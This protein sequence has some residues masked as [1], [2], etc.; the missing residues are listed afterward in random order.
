MPS[1]WWAVM[2]P[3]SVFIVKNSWGTGW[4]D[5]GFFRIAY[6]ELN[7]AVN[8]GCN[9]IAYDGAY[10]PDDTV[11]CSFS[12]SPTSQTFKPAGGPVT[13][14]VSSQSGRTWTAASNVAWVKVT[15]GSNG[16]GNGSVSYNVDAY[17]DRATRNGTLTIA[18]QTFTVTQQGLKQSGKPSGKTGK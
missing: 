9:S 6:S 3:T 8:F 1:W 17:A 13:I 2:T 18:G 15:S 4:G 5:K 16:S 7:N 14:S 11:P 12:L 10:G